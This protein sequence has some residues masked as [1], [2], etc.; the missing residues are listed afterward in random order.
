MLD[1]KEKIMGFGHAVYSTEDPRNA[2]IKKWSEKL[3]KNNG[4]ETLYLV[5]EQ[6][7][8]TMDEEKICLQI[9]IFL[10][11]QLTLI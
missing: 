7:E 4:D 1:N 9:L 2:I 11:L 3:S 8:K 5:S 10:W 6:I